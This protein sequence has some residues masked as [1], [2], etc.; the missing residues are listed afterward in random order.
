MAMDV[1]AKVVEEMVIEAMD[2]VKDVLE[3]DVEVMH[4]E[5]KDG[6]VNKGVRQVQAEVSVRQVLH[7]YHQEGGN[8]VYHH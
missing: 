1:E 6:E 5:A 7:H 8:Q 2:V 4:D 3:M